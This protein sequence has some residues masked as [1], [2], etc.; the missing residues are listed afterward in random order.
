M[1]FVTSDPLATRAVVHAGLAVTLTPRLLAEHLPGL[2]IA[3]VDGRAPRR[4][5]YALLPDVGA[6]PLDRAAVGELVRAA[7]A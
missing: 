1:P 4:T 7:R 2:R 5:L 3:E 6:R